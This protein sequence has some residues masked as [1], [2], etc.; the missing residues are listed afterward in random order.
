MAARDSNSVLLLLD[1]TD[2]EYIPGEDYFKA[3]GLDFNEEIL[4]DLNS[5]HDGKDNI[6]IVINKSD[7]INS[8]A[9]PPQKDLTCGSLIRIGQTTLKPS[10]IISCIESSNIDV[11]LEKIEAKVNK[12]II[13]KCINKFRKNK[14][15]YC[16][17]F[18]RSEAKFMTAMLMLPPRLLHGRDIVRNSKPV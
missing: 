2:L 16:S 9:L 17:I 5:D 12:I 13:C 10:A 8:L 7:K 1:V 11:L 3:K 14:K 6:I 18:Q 15:I 4:L